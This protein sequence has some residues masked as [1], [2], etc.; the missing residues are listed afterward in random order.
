[1][2]APS[3]AEV[4]YCQSGEGKFINDEMQRPRNLFRVVQGCQL[5]GILLGEYGERHKKA[6]T[7]AI[8][9]KDSK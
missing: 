6:N 3:S 5:S 2:D 4:K 8:Y 1:V 9:G 7:S